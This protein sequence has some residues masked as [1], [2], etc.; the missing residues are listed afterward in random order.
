M[1][2]VQ[3]IALTFAISL[4]AFV[5]IALIP[6]A[7]T[8]ESAIGLPVWLLAVWGPTLAAL[9]VAHGEGQLGGF[10]VGAARVDKVHLFAWLGAATPIALFVAMSVSGGGT[11]A[12]LGADATSFLALIALNLVLGPLGEELGWRGFLQTRLQAEIGWVGAALAIGAVWFVWH[13]PLWLVDSPQR[14][15]P[16]LIFAG[17]VFAYALILGAIQVWAGTSVL[18]AILF[19]LLVN[20]VAAWAVIGGF[21]A[22]ADWYAR[23]LAPYWLVAVIL[24][25]VTTAF[26]PCP[27]GACAVPSAGTQ[28]R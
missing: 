17:H 22:A 25:A 13:L 5:G 23:T 16:M 18:P 10:L 3:F 6:G 27:N 11:P 26:A 7:Q 9:I 8:P 1:I 19:H 24:V 14:E 28:S 15:I 12:I 4:L 21:G 20:L 2:Y